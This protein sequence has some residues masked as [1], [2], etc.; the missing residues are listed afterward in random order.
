MSKNTIKYIILVFILGLFG[1]ETT[2][3]IFNDEK[4]KNNQ[5]N[6][7]SIAV[8][9][10]RNN[11]IQEIANK[12]ANYDNKKYQKFSGS[13][14]ALDGDSLRF[15]DYEVRLFGIDAPEYSQNCLNNFNQEYP[16]GRISK[17]YLANIV[18]DQE[19]TCYYQK[20]DI[21][22]R[23]LSDCFTKET[24][25]NKEIIKNGMAIIYDFKETN[26]EME[27]LEKQAKANKLGVW[28]G[29]FEKPKD[30]RKSHK[31]NKNHKTI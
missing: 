26:S 18:R 30:Y 21:Y 10:I 15:K 2:N 13:A 6:Q 29:S 12:T 19:I 14:I 24:H 27:Q 22:N 4:S 16:C 9:N 28:Q 8:E 31:I 25:I 7:P 23:Y 11:N 3:L 20:K 1:F 5:Q 17:I